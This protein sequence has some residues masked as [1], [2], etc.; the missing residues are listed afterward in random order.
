MS[1]QKYALEILRRR[2]AELEE[3]LE[4]VEKRTAPA[5]QERCGA[6]FGAH[7][8]REPKGHG[9]THYSEIEAPYGTG[10]SHW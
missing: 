5:E 3:R 7:V 9:G 10:R 2:V 4:A 6:T 8:C 1:D